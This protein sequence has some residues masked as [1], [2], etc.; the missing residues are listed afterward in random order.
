MQK[1]NLLV[2]LDKVWDPRDLLAVNVIYSRYL[3]V[4]ATI[5]WLLKFILP[6]ISCLLV[7]FPQL[8]DMLTALSAV[9]YKRAVIS[10]HPLFV[11][12]FREKPFWL[13]AG[14]MLQQKLL[15][16]LQSWKWVWKCLGR[17]HHRLHCNLWLSYIQLLLMIL[18]KPLE[19]HETIVVSYQLLR[20]RIRPPCLPTHFYFVKIN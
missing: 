16:L 10:L 5:K 14:G 1:S 17:E 13:L 11:F 7:T 18:L 12:I 4:E 9:G 3:A 2:L 8:L 20:W 6:S 19:S 15:M